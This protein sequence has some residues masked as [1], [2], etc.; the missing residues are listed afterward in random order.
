MRSHGAAIKPRHRQA[1][2]YNPIGKFLSR[3][4]LQVVN[5]LQK[6][7]LEKARL[8]SEANPLDEVDEYVREE[9]TRAEV[10]NVLAAC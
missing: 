5:R 10:C 9:F 7:Y 4:S 8:D 6:H 2:P 1:E 3:H